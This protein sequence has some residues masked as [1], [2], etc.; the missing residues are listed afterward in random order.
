MNNIKLN[1]QKKI[2]AQHIPSRYYFYRWIYATI[3]PFQQ[4]AE[5]TI[6]IVGKEESAHM[7]ELYRQKKG[8]TNVLS[9]PFEPPAELSLPWLGDIILCAPLISEEAKAQAKTP[10]AH[11]AHLVVHGSLHLL[12]FDHIKKK[13]A[14]KMERLEIKILQHLKF[15]N[16]Y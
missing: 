14:A 7:N 6:R 4:H 13:D 2:K 15:D 10:L 3:S 9:F 16:P 1:L 12:G 5:L 8:P 11:W